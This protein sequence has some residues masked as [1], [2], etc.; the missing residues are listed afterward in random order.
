M[1][2]QPARTSLWPHA[3]EAQGP[4]PRGEGAGQE[5]WGCWPGRP[6]SY[7]WFL[8]CGV[9]TCYDVSKPKSMLW[10]LERPLASVQC[11]KNWRTLAHGSSWGGQAEGMLCLPFQLLR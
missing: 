6:P 2:P 3:E 1:A 7:W 8:I 9:A 10:S 4:Q 11:V 5:A